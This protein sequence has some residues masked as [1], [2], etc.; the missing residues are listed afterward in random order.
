MERSLRAIAAKGVRWTT[1]SALAA[2]GAQLL[3][4]YIA[5]QIVSPEELGLFAVVL[6]VIGFLRVF[7]DGGFTF[8]IIHRQQM[9]PEE[10]A[11]VYWISVAVGIAL[12]GAAALVGA[13]LVAWAY[14]EPRLQTLVALGALSFMIVPFGLM[15][16]TL[17]RKQLRFGPLATIEICAAL[18]GPLGTLAA[19]WAGYKVAALI[20]GLRRPMSCAP[21]C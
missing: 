4:L 2:V 7:A 21:A 5:T 13:P 10:L 14:G 11:S 15:Y 6:L 17:L 19:A 18:A 8:G 12:Y 20:F 9:S 3:Q 16:A 1:L